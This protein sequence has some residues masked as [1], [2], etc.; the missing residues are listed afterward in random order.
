MKKKN[1]TLTLSVAV[2]AII[3]AAAFFLTPTKGATRLA[4]PAFLGKYESTNNAVLLDVRTPAEFEAGHM[5]G[6]MNVDI[7]NQSFGDEIKKLDPAKTYFVYCR[8]GNRSG[9]AIA[10]MKA[11]G[12]QS[13]YELQG[14]LVSNGGVITLVK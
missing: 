3:L 9:Q 1:T 4:G 2:G 7:E 8:S 13:V 14:G 11:N 12:F 5:A 10:F 6:A